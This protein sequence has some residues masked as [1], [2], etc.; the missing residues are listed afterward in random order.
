MEGED[1]CLS[2]L[3]GKI[4]LK[5]VHTA[6]RQTVREVPFLQMWISHLE[7]QIWCYGINIHIKSN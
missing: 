5:Y 4:D 7:I 3:P 2:Q 6:G 1:T